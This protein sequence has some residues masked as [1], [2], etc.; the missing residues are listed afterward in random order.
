MPLSGVALCTFWDEIGNT[1]ACAVGSEIRLLARGLDGKW[2]LAE[3]LDLGAEI[4]ALYRT[5][6]G[7]VDGRIIRLQTNS[8]RLSAEE[9]GLLSGR[10]TSLDARESAVLAADE[11]GA[12]VLIE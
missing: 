9:V 12:C 8:G 2:A 11:F 7:L 3:G 6:A 4:T 1:C 5:F 10:V